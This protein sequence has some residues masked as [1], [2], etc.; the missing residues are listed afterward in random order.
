MK[1]ELTGLEYISF[2][3]NSHDFNY[4]VNWC[5]NFKPID[6][7]N[8]LLLLSL[9]IR[10]LEDLFQIILII[11]KH[12]STFYLLYIIEVYKTNRGG[13]ITYHGPGQLVCYFVLN[14]KKRK[15]DIRKFITTI[16]NTIIDTL[17]F[18]E[19]ETYTDKKNIGIWYNEDSKEKKVA[20]IGV[21]VKKWIA[22]H[23]FSLNI[24][25][26]LS[27]YKGIIPCGIRDKGVTNLKKMGVK[28]YNN[29]EKVII[30]KFLNTFL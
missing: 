3:L 22:Y 18:Y 9:N 28:N 25:N 30:K 27:L 20:A 21:R 26:D 23:G 17:K 15:K 12:G 4:N 2:S 6:C 13:K 7:R 16:E 8:T 14:L 29:I 11:F 24:Y 10:F 1:L 5:S 19:I